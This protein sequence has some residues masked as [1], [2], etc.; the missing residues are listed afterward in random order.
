MFLSALE[1]HEEANRAITQAQARDPLSLSTHLTVGRCLYFAGRYEEAL[2]QLNATLRMDSRYIPTYVSLA[3]TYIAM[4]RAEEGLATIQA[5]IQLVGRAPLL[6]TFA[7]TALAHVGRHDEARAILQELERLSSQRYVPPMYR[8][9]IQ[10]AMGDLDAGFETYH[11]AMEE[12]AGWLLMVKVDSGF[13]PVRQDPR[14]QAMVR[15]MGLG[16]T[17]GSVS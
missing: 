8:A 17:G 15:A 13:F 3:R 10:V 11:E 4:G 7:G 16:K 2:A 6:L 1:R 9:N 12:R 5:G 14:Y